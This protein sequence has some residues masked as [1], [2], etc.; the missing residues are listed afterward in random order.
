MDPGAYAA[1]GVLESG[2]Q[3]TNHERVGNK[4]KGKHHYPAED[5]LDTVKVYEAIQNV[6]ESPNC[7]KRHK[8]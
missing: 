4:V 2:A 6:S 5:N 7:G 8:G 3:L 1:A